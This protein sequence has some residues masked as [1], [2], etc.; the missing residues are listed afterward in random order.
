MDDIGSLIFYVVSLYFHWKMR[1]INNKNV[2]TIHNVREF[3]ST[4]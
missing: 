1:I 3:Q 2:T 4:V